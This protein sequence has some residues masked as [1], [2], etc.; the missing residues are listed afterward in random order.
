MC[1]F[2]LVNALGDCGWFY[3]DKNLENFT[4][5][6]WCLFAF[7]MQKSRAMLLFNFAFGEDLY[8]TYFFFV[9]VVNIH[10]KHPKVLVL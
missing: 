7:L 9:L 2:F 5:W 8:F 4:K 10:V 6:W 3:L 1:K